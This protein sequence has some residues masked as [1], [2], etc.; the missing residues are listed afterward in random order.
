[1]AYAGADGTTRDEMARVL[2]YPK[3]EALLHRSFAELQQELQKVAQNNEEFARQAARFGVTNTPIA[4]TVANRLFGQSGYDFREAFQLLLKT[5]YEAPFE[6]LDFVHNLEPARGRIND[7]VETQTQRRIQDLIPNGTLDRLTR[8]V[9]VNAIYLKAPWAEPFEVS[10]TAPA[11]FHLD[12]DKTI[13]VPTM[14]Q[15]HELPYAEGNGFTAL[16]LTLGRYE[17]TF[18]I[19]L[20]NKLD[21]LAALERKLSADVL[22]GKLNWQMRE[23]ALHLPRFKLEPPS[24]QL[25]GALQSLGMK[26]AF[27]IPRDSANFDRIAPRRPDD[28]LYISDVIHKTFF[29]LDEMG[30]EAAAATAI[31]ARAGGI[32]EPPKPVEFRVDHPFLFAV[33]HQ[34]SGTCLF[35]GHVADPR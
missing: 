22:A 32:Y 25:G 34:P 15:K 8:L 17:L 9:L 2:H 21:G 26:Q 1:M 16:K 35:L 23:V 4:L 19:L 3:D 29:N 11:L 30:V 24:L 10:A 18:L 33:L 28:Y 5:N 12:G 20:P 6:A 13:N 7:W 31:V 27:D 14:R